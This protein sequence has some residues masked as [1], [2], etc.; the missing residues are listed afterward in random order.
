MAFKSGLH[1]RVIIYPK[2]HNPEGDRTQRD[3]LAHSSDEPEVI[4]PCRII[5][6]EKALFEPY[7]QIA[8]G[9]WFKDIKSG[10]GYEVLKARQV[11]GKATLH[12][13]SCD[14]RLWGMETD[15][16][17]DKCTNRR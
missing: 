14:I 12:H 5:H 6:D 13:L 1:N 17:Q 8:S 11:Y 15:E 10:T 3:R 7:V 16:R 9:D 4:V 2:Q